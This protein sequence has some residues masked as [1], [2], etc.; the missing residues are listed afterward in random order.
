MSIWQK[1]C[2]VALVIVFVSGAV[3]GSGITYL[4]QTEP[5]HFMKSPRP[6]PEE[7]A[8][9]FADYYDELLDLDDEQYEEVRKM[10]VQWV[11]DYRKI[12]DPIRSRTKTLSYDMLEKLKPTLTEEQYQKW[13]SYF[14]KRYKKKNSE[15]ASRPQDSGS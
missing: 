14:D 8:K 7:R 6:T 10:L 5:E 4:L 12:M 1:N 2:I 11:K 15:P 3:V 9:Y 13:K